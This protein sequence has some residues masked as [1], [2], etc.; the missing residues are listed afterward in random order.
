[1]YR[2][3]V[4]IEKNECTYQKCDDVC[5]KHIHSQFSW[6]GRVQYKNSDLKNIQLADDG[7]YYDDVSSMSHDQA[8][9]EALL[10]EAPKHPLT[11]IDSDPSSP[12]PHTYS[13][14]KQ[15]HI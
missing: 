6:C 9:R 2:D 3:F 13:V 11:N 12:S 1:M 14:N 8:E 4:L 7:L 15:C 10:S 5:L